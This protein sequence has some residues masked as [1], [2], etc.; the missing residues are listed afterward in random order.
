MARDY[1]DIYE[2][3]VAASTGVRNAG[4]ARSGGSAET[5]SPSLDAGIESA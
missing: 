1:L 2:R 3:L 4:W 5:D